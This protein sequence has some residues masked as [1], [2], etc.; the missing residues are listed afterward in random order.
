MWV[1]VAPPAKPVAMTGCPRAFSVRAMLT[2]L[3]PAPVRCSTVR[4]RRPG[5]KFGT[6]SDLSM[7]ALSVTVMIIVASSTHLRERPFRSSLGARTNRLAN[8][9][10]CSSFLFRER[11]RLLAQALGGAPGGVRRITAALAVG[12]GDAA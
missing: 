5:L 2:P 4:W 1:P 9:G 8:P 7:A 11:P 6:A 10:G 12:A 3:P